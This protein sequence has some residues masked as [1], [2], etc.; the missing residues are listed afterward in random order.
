MNGLELANRLRNVR[1]DFKIVF[2]T[3]FS[4]HP[5]VVDTNAFSKFTLLRKPFSREEL[6]FCVRS[7]LDNEPT[8]VEL[9]G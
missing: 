9:F 1:H 4:E 5:L 7:M 8:A 3:G 2:T 6:G